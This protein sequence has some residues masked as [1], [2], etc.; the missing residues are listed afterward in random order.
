MGITPHGI[1]IS[2]AYTDIQEHKEYP[3]RKQ[4]KYINSFK[5]PEEIQPRELCNDNG[6]W[7]LQ[8]AEEHFLNKINDKKLVKKRTL[9]K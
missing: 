2:K 6:K 7:C 9:N 5:N 1:L 4:S 3:Q 8:D